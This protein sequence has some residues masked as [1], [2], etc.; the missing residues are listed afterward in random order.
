MVASSHAVLQAKKSAQDENLVRGKLMTKPTFKPYLPLMNIERRK[1]VRSD[2]VEVSTAKPRCRRSSRDEEN[3][4]IRI[5]HRYSIRCGCCSGSD[6]PRKTSR[7]S[8]GT[9][10]IT[11]FKLEQVH[12]WLYEGEAAQWECDWLLDVI[13]F[14][15]LHAAMLSDEKMF[16]WKKQEARGV[17]DHN[18]GQVWYVVHCVLFNPV[19]H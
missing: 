18:A 3:G 9:L 1:K 17:A 2:I 6:A 10:P 15:A 4:P 8:A 16:S 7:H 5:G 19:I 11:H 14:A 13:K 12:A